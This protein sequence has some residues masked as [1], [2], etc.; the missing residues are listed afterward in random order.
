MA[1]F[2]GTSGDD[3]LA[4]G[5][6]DDNFDLTLGG[7]DTAFG[8]AG[9]DGFYFGQSFTAA[10]RVDGGK[11]LD[12]LD[13]NG[14]YSA[15][16]VFAAAT[17]VNVE[18]LSLEAGFDYRL[19]LDD[20]NV[21]AGA[22]LTIDAWGRTRFDGSAETDGRFIFD[23]RSEGDEFFGG[24]GDDVV[25]NQSLGFAGKTRLDGGGGYDTL[26]T[27][28]GFDAT[29]TGANCARFERIQILNT[30]GD[31]SLTLT[32]RVVAA[33]QTLVVEV[34]TYQDHLNLSLDASAIRHGHLDIGGG[35]H[36]DLLIGGQLADHIS[37]TAGADTLQGGHGADTLSAGEGIDTFVYAS[38]ADSSVHKPDMITDLEKGDIIDLAAID[39]DTTQD[40]DQA[41]VL[42][43][44]FDGHAG[45]LMLSYDTDRN[46][47]TL[48][49]DVD[50]DGRAEGVI[51]I[52]GHLNDF[53]NF[54]L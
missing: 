34:E 6:H 7:D 31:T 29:L 21:A 44:S 20:A 10:D 25:N 45:E 30:A 11:G 9:A 50:G 15:G 47:T 2:D 46:R 23:V 27:T 22:V 3:S 36:N 26:V 28:G 4:G 43:E 48:S 49:L 52:A 13:L 24:K 19:T 35:E 5:S 1:S 40:G 51:L 54:A 8:A 18:A 32:D 12:T 42:V 53:D 38:V 37:S 33:G 17:M 41:F 39:A 16:V 14:D